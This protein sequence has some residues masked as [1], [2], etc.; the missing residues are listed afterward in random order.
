MPGL[1]KKPIGTFPVFA[2]LAGNSF[3]ALIKFAAAFISGSSVLF[4]EAIH[5]LADTGN[6]ALIAVGL[7][8]SRK[9]PDEDFVYGYG[10]ERFFWALISACGIFFLGA[11]VTIYHGIHSL[12]FGAGFE[13]SPIVFVVLAVSFVVESMTLA[14]AVREIKIK[15]PGHKAR[16]ILDIGDPVT[17]SVLLEDSVAVLGVAIAFLSIILSKVTGAHYWDGIGSIIIGIL[18]GGV[19]II[20]IIKNRNYLIGR[21]I[22]ETLQEKIIEIMESDPAIERVIDFKSTVLD[23]G[24]YRVKCEVE[25]NGNVLIKKIYRK[26]DLK[27]EYERV[28]DDYEEF[29]KF[30]VDFA[31]RVPRLVGKKI[32]EIEVK[33]KKENPEVKY[34]DIEIN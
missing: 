23:I 13:I 11:G 4:A 32:D 8:R 9:L 14:V 24:I 19:A 2:A 29:K 15:Y 31:D 7:K 10:R 26:G 3:V 5:S 21:T 18:L 20:L 16:T 28:K 33:L 27:E 22:P 17:L 1:N 30:C 12:A 6:Q 34:I 25:F